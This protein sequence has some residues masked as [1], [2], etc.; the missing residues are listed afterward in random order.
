MQWFH[1]TKTR[2][3]IKCYLYIC[4]L[5]LLLL[6]LLLL[7]ALG[8]LRASTNNIS[9]NNN[10]KT[11]NKTNKQHT[12]QRKKNQ[13][14]QTNKQKTVTQQH[15]ISQRQPD[16]NKP[17]CTSVNTRRN[18]QVTEFLLTNSVSFIFIKRFHNQCVRSLEKERK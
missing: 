9:Y 16:K 18:R 3:C 17:A 8:K 15:N 6:L 11:T 12:K 13:N 4:I 14:T 5:L 7:N 1:V 2:R 10:N